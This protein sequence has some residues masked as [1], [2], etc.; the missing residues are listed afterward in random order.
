MTST[1]LAS[2]QT[3]TLRTGLKNLISAT[4]STIPATHLNNIKKN[5]MKLER[6]SINATATAKQPQ[7]TASPKLIGGRR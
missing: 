2:D 1:L 5:G 6:L 4:H 7:R 3:I